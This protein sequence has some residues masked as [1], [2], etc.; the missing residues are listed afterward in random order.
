MYQRILKIML[1][2]VAQ[3]GLLATAHTQPARA[4]STNSGHSA[5]ARSNGPAAILALP[6]VSGAAQRVNT[7]NTSSQSGTS[8][9]VMPVRR[10][11]TIGH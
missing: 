9:K 4:T 5:I 2:A 11:G 8:A 6:P 3:F 1:I 7:P 10:P